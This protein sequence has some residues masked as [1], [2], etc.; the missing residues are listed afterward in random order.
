MLWRTDRERLN[1]RRRRI[2]IEWRKGAHLCG[3]ENVHHLDRRTC[4][5]H[6]RDHTILKGLTDGHLQILGND[7]L[8]R[9][10]WSGLRFVTA[11]DDLSR[12]L[13]DR[14]M[15]IE[16]GRLAT[17]TPAVYR[18]ID[19]QRE[20]RLQTLIGLDGLEVIDQ[21]L[22]AEYERR[23][24]AFVEFHLAVQGPVRR[25]GN[26]ERLN[27]SLGCYRCP[28]RYIPEVRRCEEN[29]DIGSVGTI[30]RSGQASRCRS[31]DRVAV[32]HI[33]GLP[34]DLDRV[35]DVDRLVD[36]RLRHG[37]VGRMCEVDSSFVGE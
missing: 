25:V 10:G 26:P 34:T 23:V 30:V 16:L 21:I 15:I 9:G 37:H 20:S 12:R 22:A 5:C 11:K 1:T 6:I 36:G 13:H 14:R 27:G 8:C 32:I 29:P 31:T 2:G 19:V 24:Y 17:G 3:Q 28:G 35:I 18:Y 7:E 33:D 4:R